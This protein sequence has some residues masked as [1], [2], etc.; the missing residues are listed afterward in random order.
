M[1]NINISRL[2]VKRAFTLGRNALLLLG[3]AC[4]SCKDFLE[5]KSPSEYIPANIEQLN[6][7]I[8]SAIP[9]ADLSHNA[10]TTCGFLD[11]LSDDIQTRGF[12]DPTGSPSPNWY[13][14]GYIAAIYAMYTW[15]PNY[16]TYMQTRGYTIFDQI[17]TVSYHRLVYVNSTL[18]YADRVT[19]DDERMR[20]YVKAQAHTLRAMYYLHLVNVYGVPYNVDPNGPGVPL[21]TTGARENRPMVRNTV[22]EAYDLIVSDL[23]Y[24]IELFEQLESTMQ[25]RQFRANM[26]M[27]LLLLSRA[28]LYMEKWEQA[29]FYAE[30]LINDWSHRF[31]VNN[32]NQWIAA[33]ITNVDPQAATTANPDVRRRQFFYPDFAN[34]NNRDVIWIY[35]AA[36]NV[37]SLT[38][39]EMWP[40]NQHVINND[41]YAIM[42]LASPSLINTFHADDLRLRTYFV[43][44]LFD[45]PDYSTNTFNQTNVRYRA[46]GKLRISNNET[47]VP[48]IQNQNRFLPITDNRAFG[49][50]L[51]FT[52]AYLT[53]AE[54]QAMLGQSGDALQTLHTVWNGRFAGGNVPAS[55]TSG[56]AVQLVRDERRREFAFE[57]MRWF[58]LR[59]WGQPQI[60]RVWYDTVF[61]DRQEFELGH[62]DPGYT[63]P[64]PATIL[65]ANP[66]L[67]QVP[68]Y[69]NGQPRRPL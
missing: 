11:I 23:L 21:R 61:G 64:M 22:G 66:D 68:M 9:G 67:S 19:A 34:Y 57:A 31:A 56:D 15:Q 12:I 25:F 48:S 63:L 13:Q 32:L 50:T 20:N 30:K 26:P 45:E 54:A 36:S 41:A 8:L 24:A 58:D 35:D 27:A 4:V 37:A 52:E 38:A 29:A 16:S 69:N 6:E 60:T 5:P 53:L 10:N 39:R 43:R 59:R 1:T 2:S 17:Y 40:G 55:Y 7:L 44:S 14:Q 47:G 28:Y 18:D 33:G 42:T 49:R 62:N 3:L 65:G 51:R 46:Y